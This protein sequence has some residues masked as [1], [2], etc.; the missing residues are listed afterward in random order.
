MKNSFEILTIYRDFV[1]MIE[2]QYSKVI[3][4]F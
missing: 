1:K 3:K 2:T 4:V